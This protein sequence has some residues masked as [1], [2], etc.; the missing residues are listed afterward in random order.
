MS[1]FPDFDWF[2]RFA[3]FVETDEEYL[4]HGRWFRGSI[5]F[6]VDQAVVTIDFD[7]CLALDVIDGLAKPD[8]LISGSRE[9]WKR[10]FDD[11]WGLVR[12]YRSQTLIIRGDPVRLMK[13]WK[14]IFFIV[15]A[16]KHFDQKN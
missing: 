8:F 2:K 11:K 15:E 13:E 10:L 7:R 9:Q 1:I 6:R 4:R 5:G 16:M 12:L 14:P 3:A